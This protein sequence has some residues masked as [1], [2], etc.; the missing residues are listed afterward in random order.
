[1]RVIDRND[2]GLLYTAG[3]APRFD[4]SRPM[5]AVLYKNVEQLDSDRRRVD[6]RIVA[7]GEGEGGARP[8][9]AGH[10]ATA[11]TL[12]QDRAALSD[13]RQ[14]LLESFTTVV[15]QDQARLAALEQRQHAIEARFSEERR[16]LGELF[17]ARASLTRAEM[18][19]VQGVLVA[20]VRGSPGP[21]SGNHDHARMV[22]ALQEKA[23]QMNAP[24]EKSLLAP[25]ALMD[26]I[27]GQLP[28][29]AAVAGSDGWRSSSSREVAAGRELTGADKTALAADWLARIRRQP[30]FVEIADELGA[31]GAV[32]DGGQ[33]LSSLFMAGVLD[34]TTITEQRMD[35]G[36]VGIRVGILGRAYRLD[37]NAYLERLPGG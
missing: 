21:A 31:S 26:H 25:H 30:R 17:S 1:T 9:S 12:D 22:S 7:I 37:A 23:A 2:D 8:G 24:V 11:G 18:Q 19:A 3:G 28:G 29:R 6:A 10:S 15:G 14:Q 36:A 5:T 34:H 4:L 16:R 20:A 27:A 13:Q 35:D 33:A 32:L